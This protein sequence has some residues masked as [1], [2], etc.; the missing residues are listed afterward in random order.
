[1]TAR[2]LL[3]GFCG[4][5]L[6]VWL[7]RHLAISQAKRKLPVLNRRSPR[8]GGPAPLVS[9]LVPA[10]DEQLNIAD[11]LSSLLAQDYPNFEVLV[12][13][14]RSRDRTAEIARRAA[15]DDYR[16]RVIDIAQLPPGWTGKTHALY[17]AVAHARGDWLLFVDADTRHEPENL[18]VVLQYAE[19]ERAD[20]VSLMPRLRNETFWEKVVS[21]L[22]AIVLTTLYPLVKVNKSKR[23]N[24]GFAN[25]Q[26]LLVKRSAYETIG[27]HRAVRSEFVEDIEL[28]RILKRAGFR[29]KV[30]LAPELSS[31]GCTS[32][33][34]ISFAAGA[35]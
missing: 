6:L 15:T 18:S 34:A 9:V 17:Q 29:T 12:A 16:V 19:Q 25:G 7:T 2:E 27:G 26:Y 22:A 14:D 4:I 23:R 20:M 31:S 21:P 24:T 8:L 11:C 5:V 13:N 1:M 32:D 35:A 28:G 33:S 3:L 10:K 30:A